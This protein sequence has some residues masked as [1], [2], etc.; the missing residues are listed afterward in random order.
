MGVCASEF[1][2]DNDCDE[3]SNSA[4]SYV[5]VMAIERG[6]TIAQ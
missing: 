3:A 2:D 4:T 6:E 5:V 1:S